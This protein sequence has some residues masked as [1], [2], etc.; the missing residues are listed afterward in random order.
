MG[1]EVSTIAN[2]SK[3]LWQEVPP[4]IIAI[5]T[6][7]NAMSIVVLLRKNIRRSNV[8]VYL[9]ALSIVDTLVL[10]T[11]LFYH[12]IK[13]KYRYDY[14]KQSQFGCRVTVSIKI[15]LLMRTIYVVIHILYLGISLKNT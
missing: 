1:L 6:F 11:G 14:R 7:G 12:W 13:Y 2:I 15:T 4:Y 10:W 8:A 5:G 3:A 9:I